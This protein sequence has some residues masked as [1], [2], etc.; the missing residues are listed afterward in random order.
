MRFSI[1]YTTAKDE[2]EAK[3]LGRALIKE[4]LV[5][6]V[7][8]LPISSMYHWE[9]KVEENKEVGMLIKTR[10]RLVRKTI[11]RIKELHTYEVPCIVSFNLDKGNKEFLKWI[12]K[13]TK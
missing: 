8:L 11:K 13:E 2:K 10:K 6:C 3:K 7:N 5:A 9:G 1:I 12:K 4:R